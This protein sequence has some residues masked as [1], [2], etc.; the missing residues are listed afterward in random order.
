MRTSISLR[1]CL[2]GVAVFGTSIASLPAA[3][4]WTIDG[5]IVG[6]Y[7]A[8]S[9][10]PDNGYSPDKAI[11]ASCLA[12]GPDGTLYMACEKYPYLLVFGADGTKPPKVVELTGVLQENGQPDVDLEAMSIH[13]GK[14]YLCDE[15]KLVIYETPL[16]HPG[17]VTK[18]DI[19]TVG[20]TRIDIKSTTR[21]PS[22]HSSL[23][24]M[25]V[26]DFLGPKA[27]ASKLDA[28]PCFYLLD[29][30]DDVA[31]RKE[32]K[33]YIGVRKGRQIEVA[34]DAIVFDLKDKGIEND[35]RLSE[36]FKYGES[37]YALK[38]RFG[39]YKVVRCD[40]ETRTLVESCDFSDFA[41]GPKMIGYDNNFEGAAVAPDGRLF[42]TSDNE[43]F[44][45][46]GKGP[47]RMKK[48]SRGKTPIVSLRLKP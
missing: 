16:D 34:V 29:E 5:E 7:G 26:T 45:T 12:F 20:T 11:G 6:R 35:F 41:N 39:V 48:E 44:P 2:M 13:N 10:A 14:I 18:L 1:V 38:T 23:E 43:N 3:A 17:P 37:L 4:Q 19:V 31:G 24:G 40:L 8:W 47:P 27:Y 25:V 28:G 36:L 9:T 30:R 15:D 42:L 21:E 33:L 22:D 32:A 46:G